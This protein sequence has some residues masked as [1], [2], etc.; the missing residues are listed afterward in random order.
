MLQTCACELPPFFSAVPVDWKH[1]ASKRVNPNLSL[2]D[3]PL[4]FPQLFFGGGGGV[5]LSWLT[6]SH[7]CSQAAVCTNN[8][9]KNATKP[10]NLT[11]W[12]EK[13]QF[14]LGAD[15]PA[16]PSGPSSSGEQA[17][18]QG[19]SCLLKMHQVYQGKREFSGLISLNKIARSG[20]RRTPS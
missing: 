11:R 13:N 12:Q 9:H 4:K 6:V 18:Y 14:V 3:F 8:R 5:A 16:R 2:F 1:A 19:N 10:I 20:M 15:R 7:H 17:M